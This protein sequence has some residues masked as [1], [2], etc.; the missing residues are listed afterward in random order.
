MSLC[1]KA[2]CGNEK[3][4]LILGYS[5]F[6]CLRLAFLER[7]DAIANMSLLP[8]YELR[9]K[10]KWMFVDEAQTKKYAEAWN[11][12]CAKFNIKTKLH[13]KYGFIPEDINAVSVFAWHSDNDGEI[14]AEDCSTLAK[15]LSIFL[16]VESKREEQG[17]DN[18][19]WFIPKR[20][21]VEEDLFGKE[22]VSDGISR[23]YDL[24]SFAAD[25]NVPLKFN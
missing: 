4:E 25:N 2:E 12:A 7:V 5:D 13:R 19:F 10:A 14:S 11:N 3:E 23:L 9:L 18:P 21:I 6:M 15:W 1:L 16:E 17:E 8:L 22:I 20:P 24:V